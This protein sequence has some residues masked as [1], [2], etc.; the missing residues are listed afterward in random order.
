M[1]DKKNTLIDSGVILAAITAF[2]YCAGTARN[3]GYLGALKLDINIL[4]RNFQQVLYE[5][6]IY[7]FVTVFNG[8]VTYIGIR[9]LYSHLLLPALVESYKFRRIYLKSKYWFLGKKK[10]SVA[11]KLAKN[12]TS[13]FAFLAF[14]LVAFILTI[15]SF[16]KNGSSDANEVLT[17]IDSKTVLDYDLVKVKIDGQEHKLYNLSCGS[18]NCAGIDPKTREV[19]YFSQTGYSYFY[20]KKREQNK[21]SNDLKVK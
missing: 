11:V 12:H 20:S 4:D 15:A 8:L 7:S 17:E 2:L 18:R 14:I 10:D 5:G 16:E 9:F 1:D 21:K 3:A 6:F 13:T 19:F